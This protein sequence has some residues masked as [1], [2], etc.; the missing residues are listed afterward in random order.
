MRNI[1][2]YREVLKNAAAYKLT[3]QT[4]IY[5][6]GNYDLPWDHVTSVGPGCCIRLYMTTDVNCIATIDGF[7]FRWSVD[8]E[9]PDA[10]G[11]GHYE[12]DLEACTMLLSRLPA[13]PRA[14]L[15]K[16]FAECADKVLAKGKEWTA[17]AISQMT[18]A[19]RLFELSR[20]TT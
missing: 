5:L 19:D 14:Q 12:I 15:Q 2:D 17:I 10:N 18:Y 20:E 11:K 3:G 8:I 13:R 1:Y 9:R 4:R 16:Y 6:H 7:E